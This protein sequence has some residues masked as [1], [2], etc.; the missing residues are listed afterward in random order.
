MAIMLSLS[1]EPA[2]KKRK[3]DT[4][5]TAGEELEIDVNA[6][7][8]PSKKALRKAKKAKMEKPASRRGKKDPMQSKKAD[9]VER[10]EELDEEEGVP[11]NEAKASIILNHGKVGQDFIRHP[12]KGL[13]GSLEGGGGGGKEGKKERSPHGIWIG[14]LAFSTTKSTL[15]TFLTTNTTIKEKDIIR[16]HLPRI[17]SGTANKSKSRRRQKE[18]AEESHEEAGNGEGK[19]KAQNR[20]F[21]YID[22]STAEAVFEALQLSESVLEG[23]KVLIK[24][25]NN[26]H[27]RPLATAEGAITNGNHRTDVNGPSLTQNSASTSAPGSTRRSKRIFLGNLPFDTNPESLQQLY[28]KAGGEITHCQVATF[29]DSG[30]CKGYA[31]VEFDNFEASEAAKRGWVDVFSESESEAESEAEDEDNSSGDNDDDDDDA[32][33]DSH[34]ETG[35]EKSMIDGDNNDK[36]LKLKR[37]ISKISKSSRKATR[38]EKEKKP[39]DKTK[40]KKRQHRIFMNRLHGRTLRTEYAEDKS[41]RYKKR[42]LSGKAGSAAHDNIAQNIAQETVDDQAE[43]ITAAAPDGS[44]QNGVLAAV[45]DDIDDDDKPTVNSKITT[46]E[47]TI[48]PVPASDQLIEKKPKKKL[49]SSTS[50]PET[51]Y[52]NDTITATKKKRDARTIKPGAVLKKAPR[53]SGAIVQG[54]GKKIVFD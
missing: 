23:R 21:A 26:F 34:G 5:T 38:E 52:S 36:G 13:A 3:R 28:R 29:E 30:K 19:G 22:F 8:P 32:E 12:A 46:K 14:N 10:N 47:T 50:R 27:G 31:W 25:A 37:S 2:S 43:I 4:T 16:I 39:N 6:P 53:E 41:Q 45:K 1:P 48:T 11:I 9:E 17:S 35:Y 15:R 49:S 40:I 54:M 18:E 20:G 7:E 24:D 42:F 51:R 33:E 44:A